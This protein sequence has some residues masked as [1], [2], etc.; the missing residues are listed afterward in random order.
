MERSSAEAPPCVHRGC[1]LT[2]GA[3][4]A[5]WIARRV[6]RRQAVS[7][8]CQQGRRGDEIVSSAHPTATKAGTRC[9]CWFG[10]TSSPCCMIRPQR[11]VCPWPKPWETVSHD[12]L[13]RLLRANGSGPP[14]LEHACRTR[15]VWEPGDL[16]LDD[17]V[18]PKPFATPMDR[19]AWVFSN[20]KRRQV[21]GFS[22]GLLVWSDGTL[23]IPL[24][25]RLWRKGP[26]RHTSW[27]WNG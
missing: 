17:T 15:F 9:P 7:M 20:R 14:L 18:I 10:S 16:I 1:C 4:P 22:L 13:T 27:L 23:R 8:T 24:L 3:G 5:S 21:Y 6:R 19:L 25:L 11:H 12:R 2:P 26:P